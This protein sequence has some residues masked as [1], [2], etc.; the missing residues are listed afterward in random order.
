[1]L[2][3]RLSL[4][5]EGHLLIADFSFVSFPNLAILGKVFDEMP[6]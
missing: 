5:N 2:L 6:Q 3:L 4:V 1:M